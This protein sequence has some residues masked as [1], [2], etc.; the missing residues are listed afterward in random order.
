MNTFSLPKKILV[1][2]FSLFL[3]SSSFAQ[4]TPNPVLT[5]SDVEHFIKSFNPLKHDLEKLEV[6]YDDVTDAW[7]ADA[8]I[9]AVFAKH[10]W[11]EDFVPKL[12]A[13]VS[14]YSYLK[15]MQE[16]DKLPADQQ[17]MMGTVIDALK[18]QYKTVVHLSDIEAVKK[19]LNAVE[20]VLEKE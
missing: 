15:S 14:A 16:F 5:N 3:C 12:T 19:R 4:T 2:C 11:G 1:F 18:S 9:K 6:A 20:Q 13:I 10:G 17:Q 7:T 8:K